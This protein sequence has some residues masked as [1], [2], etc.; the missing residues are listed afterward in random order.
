ME[1][2]ELTGY[3]FAMEN[4]DPIIELKKSFSDYVKSAKITGA[5]ALFAA[6]FI[7]I[8]SIQWPMG[9]AKAQNEKP[10]MDA[11]EEARW[12]A[13]Q[14]TMSDIIDHYDGDVGIYIKDL[15]S[16]RTF[17]HNADDAFLSASLIKLPIMIA[18]FERIWQ[19]K[20][21]L[22][23]KIQLKRQY[24]RDG[25]GRLKWAHTGVSYPVSHLIYMMMTKSD[26]TATAMLIDQ[27]GF[28]YLNQQFKDFGLVAT[29]IN[30]DG[31]SLANYLTPSKDNYTTPREMGSLLE[32]L[33]KHEIVN[34]GL[35]DLMLEIMKGADSKNRLAENLPSQWKLARKTGLLRKN[36]HD[37]GIVYTP[38]GNFIICVLT[39]HNANYRKAKGFIAS[40]GRTAYSYL[41]NS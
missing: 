37:V 17:E 2:L 26:N 27:M 21:S 5:G 23:S 20:L 38:Q 32:K 6:I 15:N 13:M 9:Q 24:R 14:N 18:T 34:D 10:V 4:L 3:A 36:C 12:V 28:D 1:I 35:S 7:G 22:S 25:S 40:I 39:Q 31:M 16:G 41:G 29:R 11:R 8:F 19:G 30:P 33:Y